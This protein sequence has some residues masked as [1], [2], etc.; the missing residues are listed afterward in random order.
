M[1]ARWDCEGDG[2]RHE[3]QPR[4]ISPATA[5]VCE[6]GVPTPLKRPLVVRILPGRGDAAAPTPPETDKP[7]LLLPRS[8]VCGREA[9][10]AA[11][12][13]GSRACALAFASAV[14]GR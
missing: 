9:E 12:A 1:R 6:R 4:T 13:A 8:A 3:L 2:A 14:R 10:A 5:G 7:P 11:S